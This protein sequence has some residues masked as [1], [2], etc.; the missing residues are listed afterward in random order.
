MGLI[1]FQL[2]AD[3]SESPESVIQVAPAAPQA[4]PSVEPTPEPT[5]DLPANPNVRSLTPAEKA[6]LG[7][8]LSEGAAVEE[9]SEAAL[10]A[11]GAAQSS[12]A[13]ATPEPTPE[14]TPIP[15]A[16]PAATPAPVVTAESTPDPTPEPTPE[17]TAEPTPE[18]TV[19]AAPT[20]G[21]GMP[22]GTTEEMWH[23][24]RECESTNNYTLAY[25][26]YHGAYQFSPDTWNWLAEQHYPDLVGI[27]PSAASPANQTMMAYQLYEV[28]GK[29]QWP[30]CG[31]HFP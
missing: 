29:G 18:A 26:Q 11:A 8:K 6:L 23:K 25:G 20:S 5:V 7:Q 21:G 31:Q 15:T 24:L 1:A 10:A 30:V 9:D 28:S 14:P 12:A 27:L 19:E 17:P 2:E 16:A 22:A 13:L 3:G 4:T